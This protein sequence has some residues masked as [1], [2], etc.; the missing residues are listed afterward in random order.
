MP[1]SR[2][3]T[4]NGGQLKD[5]DFKVLGEPLNKFLTTVG[6]KLPYRPLSASV[7]LLR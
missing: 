5:V 7:A 1:Q 2:L 4:T 6:Y 3:M